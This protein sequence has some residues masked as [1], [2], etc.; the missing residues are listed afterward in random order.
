MAYDQMNGQSKPSTWNQIY[1]H[2]TIE[3]DDCF[4]YIPDELCAHHLSDINLFATCQVFTKDAHSHGQNG[5]LHSIPADVLDEFPDLPDVLSYCV[6]CPYENCRNRFDV[7]K[8]LLTVFEIIL[9][10]V[11]Q[12]K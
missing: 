12:D 7:A 4:S 6:K 1:K 3:C 8:E 2:E 5:L 11:Q 9:K 10:A